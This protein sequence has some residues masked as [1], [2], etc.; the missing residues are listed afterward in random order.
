MNHNPTTL[1]GKHIGDWLLMRR[2]ISAGAT[3]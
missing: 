1:S 2:W 3:H